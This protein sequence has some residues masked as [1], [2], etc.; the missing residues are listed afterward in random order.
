MLS[1][2]P[3]WRLLVQEGARHVADAPLGPLLKA[4]PR[5]PIWKARL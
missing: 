4:M 5:V 2:R 3:G 1:V